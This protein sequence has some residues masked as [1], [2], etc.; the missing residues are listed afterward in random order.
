MKTQQIPEH[1]HKRLDTLGIYLRELRYSEGKTLM[2]LSEHLDIHR[3]TI[4]RAE[5]S[6]NMT[7]QTLFELA[8]FYD[9]KV[10]ELLSV[11]DE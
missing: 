7:L 11:L 9:I 4:Q 8:D 5:T 10:S 3:N 2:E 1:H 6:K